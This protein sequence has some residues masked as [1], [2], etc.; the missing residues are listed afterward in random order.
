MT[1]GP[2]ASRR[3]FDGPATCLKADGTPPLIAHWKLEGDCR[4]ATGKHHGRGHHLEFAPGRKGEARGAARF[5]GAQ[6][7]I[8]IPHHHALALGTGQFS[9][10]AWLKLDADLESVGG[11]LIGKFAAEE[12]RGFT[13][14][15]A[16]SSAGYS[17]VGDARNLHFG[18]DAGIDGSWTDCGKPWPSNPL[19]GTLTVYKGELYSGI[20]D[21][22]R[23]EDA[24]RVFRYAGGADWVDCGRVGGD[25]TTRTVY[26]M[27][28]HRGRLYAGTGT[29]NWFAVP[30]FSEPT[31]GPNHVYCFEGNGRW[32]DCGQFGNGRRV[33][34]LASF[35]GSLYAGDDT[36]RCYRYDGDDRWTYCGHLG[37]E[38]MLSTMVPFCGHLYGGSHGAIYRYDGGE[39]WVKLGQ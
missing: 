1:L 7:F 32:R 3:T 10:S 25:L 6:S 39:T 22:A 13:L 31:T 12:R 33:L 18:I 38:R 5:D 14:G 20:A 4:D 11:E 17:S 21:A 28:V 19:I 36:A 24:C 29:W 23:P 34:C 30:P 37:N 2:L 9:I 15:I 8:E 16:G 27:I 35:K 26:S